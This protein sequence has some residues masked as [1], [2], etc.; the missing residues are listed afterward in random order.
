MVAYTYE[1]WLALQ[2]KRRQRLDGKQRWLNIVKSDAEL[3][4][5]SGSTLDVL[6]AKAQAL[7]RELAQSQEA[8]PKPKP[9]TAAKKKQPSKASP[10]TSLMDR[11]YQAYDTAADELNRCA[12]A[13]LIKNDGKIPTAAEN[14]EKF[15]HRIHRKQK[16]IAR[17]EEQLQ[18]R[19]PKGRDLT[20][21]AFVKI[22]TT[23]TEQMPES[24]AQARDWQAQ[25]LTRPASLP[26]PILFGSAGELRWG[27]TAKGRIA[28]NFNGMDKYLKSVDPDLKAWLKTHKEPPFQIYCDQRHLPYFQRFLE[29][30]QAF[31]TQDDYPEGLMTLS[32][33]LLTWREGDGQGEPWQVNRLA[34]HCTFD[35]QLLTAEGTLAVQQQ[36]LASATKGLP[37]DPSEQE[38][39]DA[40]RQFLQRSASTLRRLQNLPD[41][42][43]RTPY[44]GNPEIIVGLSVGLAS[45][46]TV[47]VVNGRT[48]DVLTTRTPRS[49]LGDRHRLLNRRRQ[50]QR[51]NARQRQKNQQRGLAYQPTDSELGEYVDRLLA[52]SIVQ[53]AQTYQAGSIAIPSV[54][55]LRELLA[56]EITA[57][58]E[59]ACP[60][61]VEAQD[62]YAKQY[63]QTIHRWSYE[64]LL[65]SIRGKAQQAGIAIE[66]GFQPRQGTAQQQAKDL[67]IAAYHSRQSSTEPSAQ[68]ANG[69]SPVIKLA[70]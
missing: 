50:Q 58:A 25:L 42:P 60:G 49:L 66:S 43:S 16:E 2:K 23:I 1:S 56:S 68:L 55:H 67:A 18:A 20:G 15:T 8:Q 35:T 51:D 32:S 65:E 3:T 28:V 30:W 53:L 24:V 62:K 10:P 52:K 37:A 63:R 31:R 12:I 9:E 59:A 6:Q 48:G 54:K 45:P 17:L 22:L 64:R 26:Y 69:T 47:A 33:A 19:L 27:K 46:V 70:T 5:L 14:P 40:Q 4:E 36:K 44:Q 57:R 61:A 38:L 13:Y 29:D 11:L 41:R 39:T 7:L 21:E 34:L